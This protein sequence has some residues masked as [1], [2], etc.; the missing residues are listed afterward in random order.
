MRRARSPQPRLWDWGR[1][2]T[3]RWGSNVEEDEDS[4][5][6]WRQ[7]DRGNPHAAGFWGARRGAASQAA[8]QGQA[9]R[10][11]TFA[12]Q[13][14][15][16]RWGRFADQCMCRLL[17]G[18]QQLLS[19]VVRQIPQ[20]RL[21]PGDAGSN[22]IFVLD[23][24]SE[25]SSCVSGHRISALTG[26]WTLPPLGCLHLS[27]PCF[28]LMPLLLLQSTAAR[29]VVL[30]FC[31]HSY[32]CTP[33]ESQQ[34][35][36][37]LLSSTRSV[38]HHSVTCLLTCLH[39]EVQVPMPSDCP[40]LS[41]QPMLITNLLSLLCLPAASMSDMDSWT[42]R[43]C[44]CLS[45]ALT[46]MAAYI[47]QFMPSGSSF[48][49]VTFGWDCHKMVDW[50][51]RGTRFHPEELLRACEAKIGALPRGGTNMLTAFWT[52]VMELQS[53]A[54][55]VPSGGTGASAGASAVGDASAADAQQG[56]AVAAPAAGW[57]SQVGLIQQQ[58]V[59]L[60]DGEATDP[61]AFERAHALACNP[62]PRFAFK[63]FL[64]SPHS[65]F[66]VNLAIDLQH[67]QW[68]DVA[69]QCCQSNT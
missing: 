31:Y 46:Y 38:Q 19:I 7:R 69:A 45:R 57:G 65:R 55:V 16:E 37:F 52:A 13:D 11:G 4:V 50:R 29:L 15:E 8:G 28:G 60:T 23:I 61:Q 58:L 64:V 48:A 47:Q 40:P 3:G 68:A 66:L 14:Q 22:H 24:S 43:E 9:G 67:A 12:G 25:S 6:D 63:G 41:P 44:S 36:A 35:R 42:P 56:G 34:Q 27:A 54:G 62:A 39:L 59:L 5:D 20:L 51:A 10:W 18:R 1:R 21:S 26:T 30:R 17:N 2:D 49:V 33:P 53:K 32:P